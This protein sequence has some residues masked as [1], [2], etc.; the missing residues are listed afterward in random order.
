MESLK[1]QAEKCIS[2]SWKEGIPA[3]VMLGIIDHF[4]IPYALF[5]GASTREVGMIVAIPHL[6]GSLIQAYAVDFVRH[7]G[8]RKN[9]L[10]FAVFA[11]MLLLL[12]LAALAYT[13]PSWKITLLMLLLALYRIV[14]NLIGTAW[15]SLVSAYFSPQKRGDYFG[16]RAQ[17]TGVAGLC[18]IIVSGLFLFEMRKIDQALGFFILFAAAAGFRFISWRMMPGL[19]DLPVNTNADN[20]F[21]LI[22]FLRRFRRSNFVKFVA[23]VSAM[24]FSAHFSAPYFGVYMLRDLQFNYFLYAAVQFSAVI[25]GLI[26]FPIWGRHAD[27]IGNARVL[28]ITGFFIP[29]LPLL[30]VFTADPFLLVLNEAFSGFIWAGFNLCAVNFIYDA[31]SP[32]KRVRCIGYFNLFI[33]T[34]LFAGASLGGYLADRL[35]AI[36]N[37]T[38]LTLF[39]ISSMLRAACFYFFSPK[40][41]EV[42]ETAH[43]SIST[44]KLILSIIGVKPV[45]PVEANSFFS[46]KRWRRHFEPD[47]LIKQLQKG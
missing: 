40:F 35:P 21:T 46:L 1:E 26:A 8:S 14:G 16:W 23:F 2:V 15:G 20:D 31:V 22:M 12:P 29:F 32:E 10:L 19:I 13:G 43:Q 17:V 9:F 6:A 7:S 41:R 30:W 42:R 33:G 47:W 24:T 36:H 44:R 5:L 45:V 11:Q 25:A 34:A 18:G 37:H 38:L 4:F 28:K 39:L 27:V 3:A